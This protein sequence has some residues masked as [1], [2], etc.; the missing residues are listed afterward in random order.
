ML[1]KVT[2]TDQTI[3]IFIRDEGASVIVGAGAQAQPNVGDVG[4][5]DGLQKKL[6][7]SWILDAFYDNLKVTIDENW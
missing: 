1:I 2:S 3:Y 5:W 7:F 4:R 6:G